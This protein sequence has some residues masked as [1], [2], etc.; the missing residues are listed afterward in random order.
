MFNDTDLPKEIPIHHKIIH[1]I[2]YP[3]S[4]IPQLQSWS[5]YD[6]SKWKQFLEE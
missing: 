3:K 5:Q 6:S 4:K 1:I 2:I